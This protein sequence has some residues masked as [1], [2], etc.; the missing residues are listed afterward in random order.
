MRLL[1]LQLHQLLLQLFILRSG[2]FQRKAQLCCVRG[3]IFVG[4]AEKLKF[5]SRLEQLLVFLF[6]FLCLYVQINL[7]L[8][9][10]G[11]QL[12]LDLL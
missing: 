7:Q 10:P 11:Y 2:L 9:N 12:L 1:Q 6:V 5:L 3:I 8:G 4:L